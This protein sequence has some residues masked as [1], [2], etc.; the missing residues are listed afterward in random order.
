[1]STFLALMSNGLHHILFPYRPSLGRTK[2]DFIK[3]VEII[4]I[5]KHPFKRRINSERSNIKLKICSISRVIKPFHALF[6]IDMISHLIIFK[7]LD[8]SIKY[9]L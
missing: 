3:N 1:M 2:T 4:G 9:L 8:P 5:C 6:V 7:N